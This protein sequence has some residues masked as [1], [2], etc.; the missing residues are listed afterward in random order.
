LR[1]LSLHILDIIENSVRAGASLVAVSLCEEPTDNRLEVVVDDDGPGLSVSPEVALNPFYT[2]KSGKKTGLGLSLFRDTA[3]QAGG[4]LVLSRSPLGGLRVTAVLELNH[5]DRI[6][7]GDLAATL[8]T[9]A[10]T[11][12]E[13]DLAC[14]FRVSDRAFDVRVSEMKRRLPQS[15]R[16]DLSVARHISEQVRTGLKTIGVSCQ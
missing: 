10:C 4:D 16:D 13:L 2:T 14:H 9:V 8:S 1:D 11:N 12:P 6:P 7:L 3:R 5:I 15:E